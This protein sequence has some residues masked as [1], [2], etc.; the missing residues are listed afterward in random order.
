ML[1]APTPVEVDSREI[2]SL[3]FP[4]P[5]SLKLTPQSSLEPEDSEETTWV[6]IPYGA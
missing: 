1:L 6:F 3:Q 2:D 5:N 4:A